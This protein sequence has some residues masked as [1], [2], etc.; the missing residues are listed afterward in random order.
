V[1]TSPSTEVAERANGT[2]EPTVARPSI[3]APAAPVPS[4]IGQGTA[5]E[6]SRAVAEVQA[7]AV[8]AQQFP[9]NVVAAVEAMREACAQKG[10]AERAFFRYSRAGSQ[11][12]GPTVHLARELARCWGHLHYYVSELRRDD[13]AGESEMQATAWDVQTNTRVAN[14]FIVPHRRD[15]REGIKPIVDMRDIYENNANMAARRLRETIFAV[16]PVWF[17]DQAKEL[18]MATLGNDASGKPLPTRIAD[19]IRYYD[20]LGIAVDQLEQKLGRPQKEWAELDLAQ[21][22]VINR[23]IAAGEV[24]L[25][26]EFPPRRVTGEEIAAPAVAER[27]RKAAQAPPAAETTPVVPAADVPAEP[28]LG[29]PDPTKNCPICGVPEGARH[30]DEMHDDVGMPPQ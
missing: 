24:N 20:G 8:L 7:A 4:S 19:A 25:E 6:Q 29:D 22:L 5:V 13:H 9:R 15:T 17:T 30:D 2:P 11:I 1:T 28:M 16:L 26:D 14:T 23:S 18:C 21:L 27:P 12:T 3:A 10:L